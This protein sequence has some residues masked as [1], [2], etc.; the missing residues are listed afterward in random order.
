MTSAPSAT[1]TGDTASM[2]VLRFVP[3]SMI[4]TLRPGNCAL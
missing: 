3:S 2:F 1:K 4:S